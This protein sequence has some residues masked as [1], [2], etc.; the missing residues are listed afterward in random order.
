MLVFNKMKQVSLLQYSCSLQEINRLCQFPKVQAICFPN[1]VDLKI[2]FPQEALLIPC[3]EGW[4][5][6]ECFRKSLGMQATG[7]KHNIEQKMRQVFLGVR[8]LHLRAPV[9]S[10]MF[11]PTRR[12]VIC[13]LRSDVNISFAQKTNYLN[14][15]I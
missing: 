5:F 15:F 9:F 1:S 13:G 3:R 8:M 7:L 10:F 4:H 11:Q 2:T 6:R 14:V 12:T